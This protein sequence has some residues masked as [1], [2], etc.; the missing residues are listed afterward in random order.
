MSEMDDE[1]FAPIAVPVSPVSTVVLEKTF[2]QISAP[3]HPPT[4]P[5][6][7]VNEIVFSQIEIEYFRNCLNLIRQL[8]LCR[9]I[10]VV[11]SGL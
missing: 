5:G 10:L 3:S 6:W 8:I 11:H 1:N 4:K 9:F 7:Q 2:T